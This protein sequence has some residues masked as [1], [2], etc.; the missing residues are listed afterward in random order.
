MSRADAGRGVYGAGWSPWVRTTLAWTE[1]DDGGDCCGA[2]PSPGGGRDR[3]VSAPGAAAA[4]PRPR[5]SRPPR[6][7]AA[8]GAAG[9]SAVG[10]AA[11]VR[12]AGVQQPAG[13]VAA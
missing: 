7:G 10:R 3:G 11:G 12:A 1:A 2:G 4:D 8:A 9:P 5:R 6:A 13:A